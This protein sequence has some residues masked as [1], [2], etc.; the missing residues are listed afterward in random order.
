MTGETVHRSL[1]A[2][3]AI[4][5]PSHRQFMRRSDAIHVL[6][7]AVA[8]LARD[9][10]PDV[11]LVSEVDES[12]Q[13]VDL[14][15][16]DRLPPVPVTCQ[17]DDIGMRGRHEAVAAHAALE[18][19]YSCA[20]RAPGGAVAIL[21]VELVREDVRAVAEIN[22]LAWTL[23][24]G[25]RPRE[26]RRHEKRKRRANHYSRAAPRQHAEADAKRTPSTSPPSGLSTSF[27][28]FVERLF[29]FL[30]LL[31]G[32][33]EPAFRREA[34]VVGQVFRRP[35]DQLLDIGLDRRGRG[36]RGGG[37]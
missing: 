8:L 23:Y 34:L 20:S 3:M 1:P 10:G 31:A 36:W 30:E 33:G 4:E 21:A 15:P 2:S 27:V 13:H 28:Q 25:S 5:T 11:S 9:S 18:G 35:G 17:R 24:S 12:R 32:F 6:D 29:Q 16:G 26:A 19:G 14:Y 7:A 22:R 37:R